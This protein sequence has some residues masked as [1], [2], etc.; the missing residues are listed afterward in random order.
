[1]IIVYMGFAVV[2]GN[3]LTEGCLTYG[4]FEYYLVVVMGLSIFLLILYTLARM[5]YAKFEHRFGVCWLLLHKQ[6]SRKTT[7]KMIK[8]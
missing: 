3:V 2:R 7:D 1:M 5:H 6:K 4:S 8:E